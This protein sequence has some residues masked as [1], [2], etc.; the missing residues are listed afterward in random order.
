MNGRLRILPLYAMLALAGCSGQQERVAGSG[1]V[2]TNGIKGTVI[3]DGAPAAG[4]HVTLYPEGF[5]PLGDSALPARLKQVTDHAGGFRF[6]DVDTGTYNLIASRETDS[7]TALLP[8][9]RIRTARDTSTLAPLPLLPFGSIRVRLPEDARDS[10][11]ILYLPGTGI[12]LP[13]DAGALALGEA[14]L[15]PVPAGSYTVVAYARK[16]GTA[17][18]RNLLVTA[19]TVAPEEKATVYPFS[20]W[21]TSTRVRLDLSATGA[22]LKQDQYGFPLLVRLD[23]AHFDFAAAADGADLRITKGDSGTV[24]PFEI[25]SWDRTAG[26]AAVWVRVDTMQA[27]NAAQELRIFA[28]K[29]AAGRAPASPPVFD[30]SQGFAGVWHLGESPAPGGPVLLDRTARAHHGIPFGSMG[31]E[32]SVAGVA[33][34]G[35]ALDGKD[36]FV[37]LADAASYLTADGALT[38]SAW[39]RAGP[40][41]AGDSIRHRLVS[42]KTDTVGIS[43][44]AW[45][46]G[47]AGRMSH[48][49]RA[50]DSVYQW[51]TV[52]GADSLHHVALAFANGRFTGYLDGK[53]DFAGAGAYGTGGAF[54]VMLGA[55]LPGNR[56]FQGMIDEFRIETRA[57]S[58]EWLRLSFET[59]RPD[60]SCLRVG[61]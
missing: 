23:A 10:G 50:D 34:R 9:L 32:N 59:Q 36:D 8:G 15:A 47:S 22:G 39:I 21:A 30:T 26:T 45:G 17:P 48:Y 53:E 20:A 54:P 37:Q 61:P 49:T 43:D 57:R 29:P 6:E 51:G 13:L 58:P 4:I 44:L 24:L 5:I 2:T 16:G 46:I 55:H 14:T 11:A 3:R 25:E 38:L 28:G 31:A 33:G 27:G 35:L 41:A 1:S 60:A 18:H 42:F 12:S 56:S 40:A 19:L 52:L 7:A